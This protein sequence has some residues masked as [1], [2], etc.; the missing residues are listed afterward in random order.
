MSEE[1][2]AYVDTYVEFI[3]TASHSWNHG[4]GEIVTALI[5]EGLTLTELTEHDSVPWNALPGQLKKLDGGEWRVAD[6]PER[7]AHCYTLQAV[8][9]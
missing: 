3:H 6:R 7:L 2:R 4:L 8:K 1:P 5:D 9:P